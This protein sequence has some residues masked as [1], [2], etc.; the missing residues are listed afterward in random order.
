MMTVGESEGGAEKMISACRDLGQDRYRLTIIGQDTHQSLEIERLTTL[1]GD[2]QATI[3]GIDDV[4]TEA[5]RLTRTAIVTSTAIKAMVALL[6]HLSPGQPQK[7]TSTRLL[8]PLTRLRIKLERASPVDF[9]FR[10][11]QTQTHFTKS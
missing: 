4:N 3:L 7:I 2:F 10:Q 1:R 9:L 8:L 5:S 11:H 6:P